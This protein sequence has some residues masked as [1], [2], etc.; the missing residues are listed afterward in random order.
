MNDETYWS[1]LVPEF[2]VTDLQ[3]SIDFYRAAGFTV[4]FRRDDPPFAYLEMGRAQLMLEQQHDSGWNIEPLDRPLGRGINFQV[5]VI[6]AHSTLASLEALGVSPFRAVK[7]TW[8][9]VSEQAEK[10]Q[11]EFLVQDPDGYL[12]RFAQSLGCRAV[13]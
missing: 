8:Y 5:E 7:D 2:T 6:D 11:R 9:A 1:P 13:P 3:T 12:M 10:G 4:R